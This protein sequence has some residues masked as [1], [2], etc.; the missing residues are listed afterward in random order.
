MCE[1]DGSVVTETCWSRL[2]IGGERNARGFIGGEEDF[3]VRFLQGNI[4]SCSKGC[5]SRNQPQ[6]GALPSVID[7]QKW[8]RRLVH[9][10][11]APAGRYRRITEQLIKKTFHLFVR[12]RCDTRMMHPLNDARCDS[13]PILDEWAQPIGMKYE[14]HGVIWLQ[15]IADRESP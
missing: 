13:V 5:K 9:I 15:R 7:S 4:L 11:N 2:S 1:P 8:R 10:W 3:D 6:C 12:W 14:P